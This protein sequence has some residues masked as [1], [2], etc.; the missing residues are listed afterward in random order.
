MSDIPAP[1]RLFVYS[2]GFLAPGLRR[3]LALAGWRVMPGRPGFRPGAA[4]HVGVWARAPDGDRGAAV[5]ARTGAR[6]VRIDDAPLRSIRPGRAGE[7]PLGL[8]IDARGAHFDPTAPSEIEHLLATHPLDDTA[9]LDRARGLVDTL[10]AEDLS[11]YNIH[12]PE[13]APPAP[14]YVL[15]VDQP[16][17]DPA[18]RAANGTPARFR[19]MLA[20][21]QIEHPGARILIKSHPQTVG[22]IRSG[23]FGPEHEDDRTSLF[24]AAASPWA[25]LDGAI[26]VYTFSSQLGLEA[27][28]AGHRPRVFGQPFY[29]G[30]GL[31]EDEAP[32]PRRTRRLTRAQLAAV[33]YLL[34]PVWY[35][36]CRDALCPGEEAAHHLAARARAFREDR[37]GYVATGVPRGR[38][39]ALRAF[40]GTERGVAIESRPERAATRAAA[41]AAPLLVWAGDGQRD[42]EALDAATA[43]SGTPLLRGAEGLLRAPQ[44]A[45]PRPVS[46]LPVW[47]SPVS[48]PPVSLL[49]DSLLPV[50]LL[51]VSLAADDLAP[52]DD[53]SCESRLE[54]LIAEAEA[55][56]GGRLARASRL[57][58]RLRAMG[59]AGPDAPALPDLPALPNGRRLLVAGQAED[60]AEIRL[61]ATGPVRSNRALLAAARAAHPDAAILYLPHPDVAAGRG[62]GAIPE[63]EARAMADAAFPSP[64]SA[65]RSTPAGA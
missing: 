23:H 46:L 20:H 31:T 45:A 32:V 39:N 35:D 25:L 33:A 61:G 54:R 24:T 53:P 11:K 26:A 7:P 1:R 50:S 8:L 4:D 2:A 36:P 41:A 59:S 52:P 65:R 44:P 48:L 64:A 18:A 63:A 22:G 58:E 27:I 56:P 19:E 34:A 28:L 60:G 62:S 9:L 49:P 15:V 6:L 3:V 55:L 40:Y 43:R 5:A 13:A 17:D 14:G 47:L 10:S 16:R 29:G 30:W 21:A 57:I 38:R 42:T 12:V 37:R 51:P